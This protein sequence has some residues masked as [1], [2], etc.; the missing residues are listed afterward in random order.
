MGK[1][2][3]VRPAE[4][5]KR[6][7]K[8]HVVKE[9]TSE[10]FYRNKRTLDGLWWYCKECCS[11]KSHDDYLEDREAI[12][13]RQKEYNGRENLVHV[14][15]KRVL[16]GAACTLTVVEWIECIEFFGGLDAYSGRTMHKLSMDHVV[17][18]AKHG[19]HEKCNV[20]PCDA[21]L[22]RWKHNSD[23]EE[24]YRGEIFFDEDRLAKIKE[25]MSRRGLVCQE[26]GR[27]SLNL[28]KRCN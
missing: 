24:W 18:L 15:K 26:E 19:G 1:H 11:K 27:E 3:E 8:C 4:G 17:P 9:A 16:P 25:W 12:I 7:S 13:N 22:N 21:P 5:M 28:L 10:F 14:H 23:M 20:I 6:C 2:C